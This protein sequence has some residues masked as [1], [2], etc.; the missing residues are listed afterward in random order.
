MKTM[1]TSASFCAIGFHFDLWLATGERGFAAFAV[2]I[3]FT[4]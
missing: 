2:K 1:T 3:C 4:I